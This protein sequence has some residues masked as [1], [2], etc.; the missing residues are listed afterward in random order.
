M[1][2]LKTTKK[3]ELQAV[4]DQVHVNAGNNPVLRFV[5]NILIA[6]NQR[7]NI[8]KWKKQTLMATLRSFLNKDSTKSNKIFGKQRFLLALFST[9]LNTILNSSFFQTLLC[10]KNGC[11]STLRDVHSLYQKDIS[12]RCSRYIYT[13]FL[14]VTIGNWIQVTPQY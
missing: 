2:C 14:Y 5:W 9:Q 8:Q 11:V 13:S 1:I 3:T 12:W 4:T 6:L 10:R 7:R